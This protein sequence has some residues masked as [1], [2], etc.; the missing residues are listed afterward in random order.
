MLFS[1]TNRIAAIAA[2]FLLLAAAPSSGTVY[3]FV[4]ENGAMHF[5]NVPNDPRYRPLFGPE[6]KRPS[7]DKHIASASA[8]YDVDPLLIKAVIQTES[9]FDR[10]AVSSKGAKGLMQLMP[11]TI[12]D[13]QVRDPFNPK[14]NI[15]GGTH[16]LRNLLDSFAGDLQ[17]SLA[18]YNA[19]P[20]RVRRFGGIPPFPETVQYVKKVL[21]AYE[22]LQNR[23]SLAFSN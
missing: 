13:M 23:A 18:A 2:C 5:T 10:Y 15:H 3:S 19:G 12:I 17:L 21:A 1:R 6:T 8:R 14:E 20:E 22:R 11:D 9:N 4:D 16:Y 7:Y